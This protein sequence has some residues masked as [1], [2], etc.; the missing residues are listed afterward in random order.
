MHRLNID[1]DLGAPVFDNVSRVIL[2]QTSFGLNSVKGPYDAMLVASARE[3][4]G[5]RVQLGEANPCD[6]F[7]LSTECPKPRRV[8]TQ[9]GGIPYSIPIENWPR[10]TSDNL[11]PFIG[12]IDFRFSRDIWQ[13]EGCDLLQVFGDI[14]GESGLVCIW[15]SISATVDD[16][17]CP[18]L[19]LPTYPCLYSENIWRIPSF[20]NWTVRSES[21]LGRYELTDGRE[22]FDLP[23]FLTPLAVQ[24]CTEPFLPPWAMDSVCGENEQVVA[25]IP[26]IYPQPD[27][28]FEFTNTA[29]PLTDQESE[30]FIFSVGSMEV[31]ADNFGLIYIVRTAVGTTRAS[32]CQL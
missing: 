13:G 1:I 25:M 9:L 19:E 28:P 2:D 4:L 22:L 31:E 15:R 21:D 27:R 12:Q 23:F 17:A 10:D 32:V 11:L 6:I 24:I 14:R 30:S 20:P 18:S 3:L 8:L 16:D 26:T 29:K 7:L 5:G